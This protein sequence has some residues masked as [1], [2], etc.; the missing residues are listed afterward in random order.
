MQKTTEKLSFLLYLL[1]GICVILTVFG[2]YLTY[3]PAFQVLGRLHPLLLHLP[4]GFFAV[5]GLLLLF[6]KEFPEQNFQKW[7]RLLAL[8]NAILACLTMTF[9]IILSLEPGYESNGILWH[10]RLGIAFTISSVIIYFLSKSQYLNIFY[11][12]ALGLLLITGHIGGEITHGENFLLE[13]ILPKKDSFDPNAPIFQSSIMPIFESKCLSCHNDQ[14]TKGALNMSTLEKLIKG[15]KNGAVWVAGKAAESHI[16]QR[17]NLPTEDKK[18]MPPKGKPQPSLAEISL[19]KTWIAQGANTK[20]TFNELT[21]SDTL[22]S[23]INAIYGPKETSVTYYF[24]SASASVIEKLNTPFCVVEPLASN[25]PAVKASFYVRQKFDKE[26]LK[27]LQKINEQL[28]S[29]QLNKMPIKDEDLKD[30]ASFS[31]LEELHLN[32]TD[33]DGS[34]LKYLKG[35]KKLSVLSLSGTKL[36]QEHVETLKD[37][38]SVKNLFVWNTGLPKEAWE[39]LDKKVKVD[40]GFT[41]DPN[42]I[43]TLNPPSFLNKSRVLKGDDLVNIKHTLPGVKIVYAFDE[44][45][46]DSTSKQVYN[47]PLK[48]GSVG[49]I[50]AMAIK[51]GW[52][53]SK[54]VSFTYFRSKFAIDSV[55]LISPADKQ[56]PGKGASTLRDRKEGDINNFK[57]G[58]WLGYKENKVEVIFSTKAKPNGLT[59]SYMIDVGS[60]I[61]PP[62]S[63]ELWGHN[64]SG[65]W[66]LIEKH[67]PTQLKESVPK[68]ANAASFSWNQAYDFYKIIA[69]PN[70]KLPKWHGGA[71]QKA[72]VFLDEIYLW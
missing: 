72:W 32:Q 53:A 22:L 61:M 44:S 14:K 21:K 24:E 40:V 64:A 1:M 10:Q 20:T 63:V 66:V 3:R 47:T 43:L 2:Q 67:T 33:I 51:D 45:P 8:V 16:I 68:S 9:G 48:V 6:R 46:L 13:S 29:L 69:Y 5:M 37:L 35:L 4:I 71:G 7:F 15:G 57:D 38:K 17:L 70:P 18:H 30:L 25:S 41:P 31:N 49:Q 11:L 26:Q 52:L 54:P 65:K 39:G 62:V 60:F 34:G 27:A 23:L 56:Y 19:L 36:R 55:Q 42:D 50:K 12:P 58:S 28:V 59:L